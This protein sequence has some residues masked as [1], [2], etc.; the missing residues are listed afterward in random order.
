MPCGGG[1]RDQKFRQYGLGEYF[2]MIIVNIFHIYIKLTQF[3][4]LNL[5]FIT[6]GHYGGILVILP[7]VQICN[8]VVK[9]ILDHNLCLVSSLGFIWILL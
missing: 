5:S 8:E 9:N 3:K 2:L 4:S 7:L 1:L 6:I